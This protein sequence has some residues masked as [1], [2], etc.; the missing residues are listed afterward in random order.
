LK[1]LKARTAKRVKKYKIT[2]KTQMVLTETLKFGYEVCEDAVDDI[3]GGI[4]RLA[5]PIKRCRGAY[6]HDSDAEGFDQ[7]CGMDG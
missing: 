7:D 1:K 4:V 5:P 2:R 6:D 3:D